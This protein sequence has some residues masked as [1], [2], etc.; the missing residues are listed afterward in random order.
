MWAGFISIRIGTSGDCSEYSNEPSD[1]IKDEEFL[2]QLGNC[3]LL[4]KN[5]A[6][7]G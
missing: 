3:R 7:W 2:D 6:P 5:S 4:E 1:S